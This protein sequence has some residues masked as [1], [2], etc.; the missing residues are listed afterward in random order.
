MISDGQNEWTQ[1]KK[2]VRKFDELSKE[3]TTSN[4]MVFF[5]F[6]IPFRRHNNSKVTIIIESM[7]NKETFSEI[8]FTSLLAKFSRLKHFFL[9]KNVSPKLEKFYT[10]KLLPLDITFI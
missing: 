7:T 6:L 5:F 1:K 3:K 8:E 4:K 9:K 10:G 2:D